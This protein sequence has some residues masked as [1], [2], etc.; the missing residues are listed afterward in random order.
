MAQTDDDGMDSV[1]EHIAKLQTEVE[2]IKTTLKSIQ[3]TA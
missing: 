2:T 1:E 3:T